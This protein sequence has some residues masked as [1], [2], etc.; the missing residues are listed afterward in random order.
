MKR[1]IN[2]VK[3]MAKAY[4]DNMYKLYK[5]CIDAGLCMWP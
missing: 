5:P 2:L 4:C 1:V 3:R